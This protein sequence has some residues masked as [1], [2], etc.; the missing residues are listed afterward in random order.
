[1][2]RRRAVNSGLSGRVNTSFGVADW[3]H[4]PFC[5]M[6]LMERI[7]TFQNVNFKSS[8]EIKKLPARSWNLGLIS[9]Q[10]QDEIVYSQSVDP[11][12]EIVAVRRAHHGQHLFKR[13]LMVLIIP[14]FALECGLM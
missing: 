5:G 6:S 10:A 9:R 8:A 14:A 3:S 12:G 2:I 13:P 11:H 7:L 1:M 4:D